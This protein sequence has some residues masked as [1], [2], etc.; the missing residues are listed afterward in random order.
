MKG[1]AWVAVILAVGVSACIVALAGAIAYAESAQ[2]HVVSTEAATLLSTA[3]GAVV[4]ALATYLGLRIDGTN[5]KDDPALSDPAP[6]QP[7]YP[8]EEG[9]R[10]PPAA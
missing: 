3:L 1:R 9:E 6:A 5:G 10:P 7:S 4:G 2:G 8:A